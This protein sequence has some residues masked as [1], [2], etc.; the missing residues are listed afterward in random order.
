MDAKITAVYRSRGILATYWEFDFTLRDGEAAGT[1]GVLSLDEVVGLANRRDLGPIG[2]M[3][4]V[5]KLTPPAQFP[6]LVGRVFS[7]EH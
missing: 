3:C 5:I 4:S 7:S 6:L 1:R 2:D